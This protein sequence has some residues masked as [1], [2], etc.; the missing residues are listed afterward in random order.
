MSDV[1]DFYLYFKD[2][3]NFDSFKEIQNVKITSSALKF[4][5]LFA[6]CVEVPRSQ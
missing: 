3:L 2:N 1:K 4:Q 5:K 6:V